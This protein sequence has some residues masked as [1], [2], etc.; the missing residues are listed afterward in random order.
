MRVELFRIPEA[1][2]LSRVVAL[3]LILVQPNHQTNQSFLYIEFDLSTTLYSS[4]T[5]VF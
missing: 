2:P 4:T 5:L 1:P 3:A